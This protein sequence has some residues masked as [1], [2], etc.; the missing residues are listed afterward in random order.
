M[1]MTARHNA[2]DLAAVLGSANTTL[3]NAGL[4]SA[5]LHNSQQ[6]PAMFIDAGEKQRP[7]LNDFKLSSSASERS[8]QSVQIPVIDLELMRSD[9]PAVRAALVRSVSEACEK[10]GFFQVVNHGVDQNLVQKCEKEAHRMFELPLDVKER[11]HRPPGTSFGYGANTW[12]NQTVM[13]WAESFHMQLH[14]TSNIRDFS[15][16]LFTEDDASQFRYMHTQVTH[17]SK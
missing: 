6:L 13:H 10:F 16:K 9:N 8:N 15:G 7:A 14:P 1:A 12:V 3:R 11:V 17:S 5:L 4:L 2:A